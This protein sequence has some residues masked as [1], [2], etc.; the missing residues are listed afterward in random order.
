MIS[1]EVLRQDT[2]M[3]TMI[4][5]GFFNNKRG[6]LKWDRMKITK[7]RVENPRSSNQRILTKEPPH[8]LRLFDIVVRDDD[9]VDRHSSEDDSTTN[10]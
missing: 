1:R 6:F 9:K 8:V 2:G 4:H 3:S 5:S 7:G 10:A